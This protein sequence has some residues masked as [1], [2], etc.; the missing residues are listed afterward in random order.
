M[1][2]KRCA[3]ASHSGNEDWHGRSSGYVYHGCRC[4]DCRADQVARSK[5]S[6][7]SHP[8][9]GVRHCKCVSHSGTETWHGNASGYHYHSCRCENCTNAHAIQNGNYYEPTPRVIKY[10][11]LQG[12][13]LTEWKSEYR[14][15]NSD[16]YAG[17]A[18]RRNARKLENGIEPYLDRDIFTRDGWIC[19]LCFDSV[20]ASIPRNRRYGAT[21][22]HVIPISKGGEDSPGN[23]QLAHWICNVRKNDRILTDV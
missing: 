6:H 10:P 5:A 22:D 1:T 19:Q 8:S 18:R 13:A 16:I 17:H 3:C 21:I 23:V 9:K 20:D 14:R 12:M 15:I 7:K 4:T 2:A 11:E